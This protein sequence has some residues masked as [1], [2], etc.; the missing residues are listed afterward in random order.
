MRGPV[1]LCLALGVI[2]GVFAS[3]AAAV[4]W[5]PINQPGLA[6]ALDAAPPLRFEELGDGPDSCWEG[7]LWWVPN[8]DGK[9][10]DMVLVYNKG[11]QGPHQIFIY[12]TATKELKREAINEKI[13]NNFHIVPYFLIGG[14][15]LIK[16]G[17]GAADVKVYTYDPATNTLAFGGLPAGKGV[18]TGDGLLAPNEDGSLLGGF[19]ALGGDKKNRDRVGFYTIDPVTLKG[20]FL[21]EVGPPSSSRGW[22]L[23]GVVMDG[24]WIYARYGHTPWRLY[25][26]NVKTRQGSVIAE[27]ERIIGDRDTITFRQH[28][29]HPGVYVT[30]TGMKGSSRDATQSFWLRDGELTPCEPA[31][32][33]NI[34]P[35]PPWSSEKLATPRRNFSGRMEGAANPPKGFEIIRNPVDPQGN[36]LVW[37]RYTDAAMAEAARVK[38]GE[39]QKIELEGLTLYPSL[40]RRM[41][42]LPDDSLIALSEGY[43]RAVRFNP[44]TRARMHLGQTM[45]VYSMLSS[46]EK[47]YLCG[48][49]GSQVWIYDPNRPWTAGLTVET[50]TDDAKQGTNNKSASATATT[51]PANVAMLKE[52][53]DVHMPIAAA[54]GS[55][56]RIYFGGKVVRIGNGGGL[57]WWDT[58]E[59]TGGGF[60]EP[61]DTDSI[62]WMCSAA[63]GRY[64]VCSTKPVAGRNNPD[65]VP[66]RGRLFVYDT[67]TD[68]IIHKV[69]DERL[70]TFPGYVTEALPGLVMGYASLQKG[71][72]GGVLYGFDP[73][74]GK[75]LWTKP[76]PRPPQTA[77]SYVRRGCYTFQTGPDGLIWATMNGVLVR[78]DPRTA[79]VQ[80][81]GAMA[82]NPIAFVDGDIYVAG[83]EQFRRIAG[84][85]KLTAA[86]QNRRKLPN[87]K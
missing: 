60:H 26:V 75:V 16:P 14:R 5:R 86:K 68:Q 76:V 79:E 29:N 70:D 12:D 35:T 36:V 82:D 11:Y 73:A 33:R 18:I 21:G 3:G 85:P 45:S 38:V 25:G 7:P 32:D 77:M 66:P 42:V 10:W 58:K 50:P 6:A 74:A 57:G 41:A 30:I 56:G 72:G 54:A 69:D 87:K 83:G 39:W 53:N 19:G 49:P 61:F 63:D 34:V 28:P 52:F 2:S 67:E 8:P 31:R 81:V 51:N 13:G 20:E 48:Y 37:Y 23:G 64:I 47:L 44:K 62:F 17:I 78:I 46:G 4:E 24:D 43:A 15:M 71:S 27:T 80:P 9:T 22:E 59:R 1:H 40:I 84:I 55:D 65:Y